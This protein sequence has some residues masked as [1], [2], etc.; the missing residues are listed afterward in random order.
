M[1][2][3]PYETWILEGEAPADMQPALHEHLLGCPQCRQLKQGWLGVRQE[4]RQ[5]GMARPAAGFTLRWQNS[6]AARRAHQQQIQAVKTAI[7][8][9]VALFVLGVVALGIG[10][11]S[12]SPIQMMAGFSRSL[13]NIFN[14]LYLASHAAEFWFK[15]VP[16][17]ITLA[18]WITSATAALLFVFGWGVTLWRHLKVGVNQS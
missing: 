14:W 18:I 15:A 10:L 5:V 17:P 2:H 13:V 3:L 7:I 16:L 8:F 11:L 6:L 9:V 4:I 12:F 1:N